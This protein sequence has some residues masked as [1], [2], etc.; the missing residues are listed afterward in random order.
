[1]LHPSRELPIRSKMDMLDDIVQIMHY[2]HTG[3][4]AAAAPL[5]DDLKI[6][7]IYLDEQ[8]QQN[9]LIF[10]SQVY[11][12]YDYDPWHKITPDVQKSADRLIE[13]LGFTKPLNLS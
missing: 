1:M 12:Q 4:R 8:I 10:V 6:R 5:L 9:V 2:L 13:D 11:F 3:E 7:S